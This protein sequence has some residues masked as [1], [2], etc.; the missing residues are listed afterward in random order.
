MSKISIPRR[1]SRMAFL[2]TSPVTINHGQVSGTQSNFTVLISFTDNRFKTIGNGGHVQSSSGFDIRPYQGASPLSYNLEFYNGTTGQ[3]VLW[4]KVPSINS[5][6]DT[7]L[8]L[9]YD[10]ATLATDGSSSAAWDSSYGRVYHLPNGTVLS[11]TDST[12]NQNGTLVNTPTAGAGKIDG[13]G[14]FASASTQ[15][16][17]CGTYDAA[18]MTLSCW[19]NG[20]TFPA[21][22]NC[23]INRFAGAGDSFQLF[24]KSTGQLAIYISATGGGSFYDPGTITLSTATFYYLVATYDSTNGLIGYV[25][26]VQD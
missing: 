26:A 24:V 7:T 14:S 3:V 5:V 11:A 22:Y 2:F 15:Y 21:A 23:A 25:N 12:G 17:T 16:I 19:V 1:D 4:A 8:A 10:D 9:N 18:A 6:N 13:C 20:T